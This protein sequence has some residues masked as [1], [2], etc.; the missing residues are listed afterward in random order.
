MIP[1]LDP[2]SGLLFQIMREMRGAIGRRAAEFDITPQQAFLLVRTLR[3]PEASPTELGAE[4]GTDNAGITRL[5][6]RL[7]AKGLVARRNH[8]GDRRSIVIELTQSGQELA[9]SLAP[10]FAGVERQLIADLSNEEVSHL[11]ALLR[12]LLANLR[13][14][15]A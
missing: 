10:I 8:P 6:D 5:V 15:S 4:V 2:V 7:E 3:R 14:A 1:G 13:E 11:K 9:P 12:R